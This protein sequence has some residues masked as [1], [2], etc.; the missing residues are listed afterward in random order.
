LDSTEQA[1]FVLKLVLALGPLAVYFLTLGLVNS[2]A[3]PHLVNARVDFVL[4]AIAFV[5]VII[6][7]LVMLIEHGRWWL[8]SAVVVVAAGGFSAALP[9]RDSGWVIYNIGPGQCRRLLERACCRLGWHVVGSDD[10]L[11]VVEADLVVS[12]NALPWLRNVTVRVRG[13]GAGSGEAA[14]ARLLWALGREIRGEAMLPSPTGASLVVVGAGLL[15]IP[16]WYLFRH[17]DA[18]VDVVRRVLFA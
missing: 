6:A 11:Q 2:Q 17:M 1:A 9:G 13:A 5:P 16:M 12:L 14:R 7:P 10:Q 4:L 3:R 15:G 8:A 18:I